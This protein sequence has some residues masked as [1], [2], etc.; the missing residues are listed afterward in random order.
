MKTQ[1]NQ[2]E[3]VFQGFD[4]RPIIVKKDG[5]AM[6]SDGG[7]VLLSLLDKKYGISSRMA[8]A[9]TD[10]RNPNLV[11]HPVERLL[12]QRIYGLCQGYED[13]NDHDEWRH[14]PL[15]AIACD[16]TPLKRG[17]AGKSTLN[18]LELG[19]IPQSG[20]DRY[21]NI[22]YDDDMLKA[23]LVD[24]FLESYP[25]GS[26]GPKEIVIDVD[27]TDDPLYG[28]QEG[29]YFHG[30][31]D[32]YCYLPLYMFVGDFPLWAEIHTADNDPALGVIPALKK[33]IPRIRKRWKNTRIILRGDSGFCRPDILDWCETEK[34]VFYVIGIPKN[35]RLVR[36]IGGSLRE[37]R[38]ICEETGQPQ[39]IFRELRYKTKKTWKKA[40][41]VVGKAE[42]IPG[43]SNPRFIVTNLPE[44]RWNARKLYEKLYCARGN[45]ENRIK[46]Q[47]LF[48][49]ADRL[50]CHTIR[51][52][53][54][55]L[56]FSTYAYLFTVFIRFL[57]AGDSELSK[58]QASTIRVKFLKVAAQ[59]KLSARRIVIHIPESFPYWNT[60]LE[61]K[62]RLVS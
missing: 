57:E 49:F 25:C 31:Y 43:R 46:E 40:R 13:V 27:S 10:I 47:K 38:R 42:H 44:N 18:R 30:F 51:S 23:L 56:W 4:G 61:I 54:L 15:L 45:M 60:W 62:N 29:K 11:T 12:K 28:N 7:L 24:L 19:A 41:R 52:N 39:R 3:F 59:V 9:F 22:R 6:S 16:T 5:E 20:K 36:S 32:E 26:K 34:K 8:T 55:R 53:Q 50:S 35:K 1:C 14:D 33:I 21:K 17:L 58:V 37:A 48:L 2:K